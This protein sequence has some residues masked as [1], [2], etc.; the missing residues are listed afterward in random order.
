MYATAVAPPGPGLRC[1]HAWCELRRRWTASTS[2]R[3]QRLMRSCGNCGWRSARSA[4]G[5]ATQAR[6]LLRPR[7]PAPRCVRAAM[8]SPVASMQPALHASTQPRTSASHFCCSPLPLQPT[9]ATHDVDATASSQGL[10][11]PAP[12]AQ[13]VAGA[14]RQQHQDQGTQTLWRQVRPRLLLRVRPWRTGASPLSDSPGY[15][16]LLSRCVFALGHRRKRSG[17]PGM[18]APA[19]DSGAAKPKKSTVVSVLRSRDPLTRRSQ[20]SARI[21]LQKAPSKGAWYTWCR[22]GQGVASLTT[23]AS[24]LVSPVNFSPPRLTGVDP[25]DAK[26]WAGDSLPRLLACIDSFPKLTCFVERCVRVSAVCAWLT[27]EGRCAGGATG[28][29][30]AVTAV[31]L[32]RL[33]QCARITA[34]WSRW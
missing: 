11:P 25:A 24:G 33:W 9:S 15:P 3:R 13:R 2:N 34:L 29:C 26:L 18:P 4:V 31:V 23:H 19:A 1:W 30:S 10:G 6:T 5:S 21:G 16:R 32:L 7:S 17:A 14:H 12:H 27:G 20:H 8:D 28:T 22:G